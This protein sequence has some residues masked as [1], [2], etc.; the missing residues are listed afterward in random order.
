MGWNP[1]EIIGDVL[2]L[3]DKPD[4]TNQEALEKTQTDIAL[5]QAQAAREQS[6]WQR[7]QMAKFMPLY[8]QQVQASI[9]SQ[10]TADQRSADQ[11]A[12]F[13]KYFSPAEARLSEASLNYDT[14]GRRTAAANEAVAGVDA[15]FQRAREAQTR[16]LGRAG[17]SLDSGRALSLDMAGRYAQAKA[18]AGADRGAR[19]QIENTGLSLLDN[20]VKTGRGIA[21]TSLQAQGLGLQAGTAATGQLGQQQGTYNASLLPANNLYNGASGALSNATTMYNGISRQQADA[22]SANMNGLLGLGK[23]AATFYPSDPKTKKVHG[24]VSGK[25]ALASLADAKVMKWTYKDGHGDGGTHIGRMAGKSDPKVDGLHHVDVIN[26][27]GKHHAAIKELSKK[28]ASLADAVRKDKRE[29]RKE[30][31]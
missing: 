29:D 27:F 3:N 24:E 14:A 22:A 13:Q 4:T 23:L 6:A 21:S 9:E 19:Q 7:E 31:A 10:K 25:K 17:I 26:E 11:W 2:G 1:L 30:A 12:N 18:A 28:V 5:E 16:D 15:Q 8:E 20:V